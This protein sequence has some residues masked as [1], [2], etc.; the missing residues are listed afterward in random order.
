MAVI[1][2][3]WLKQGTVTTKAIIG[4]LGQLCLCKAVKGGK[5]VE[6]SPA[7]EGDMQSVPAGFKQCPPI[8][9]LPMF[10]PN[11]SKII[12]ALLNF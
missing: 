5:V 1:Q 7:R 9:L 2:Q 3:G 12:S 4:G 8:L 10:C 6:P 11:R